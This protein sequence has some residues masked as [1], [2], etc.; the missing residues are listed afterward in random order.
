MHS[1]DY[2]VLLE[3]TVMEEIKSCLPSKEMGVSL[4]LSLSGAG[5]GGALPEA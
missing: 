1:C 5:R 3:L 2:D 4:S